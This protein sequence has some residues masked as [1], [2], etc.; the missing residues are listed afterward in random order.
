[1]NF[2]ITIALLATLLTS[3]WGVEENVGILQAV[4]GQ[5]NGALGKGVGIGQSVH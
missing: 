2:K 4:S 3:V 5:G 1:M